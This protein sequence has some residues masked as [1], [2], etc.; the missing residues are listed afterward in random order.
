MSHL[1]WP[2]SWELKWSFQSAKHLKAFTHCV[3]HLSNSSSELSIYSTYIS[4]C[5]LFQS[6]WIL[7]MA[8]KLLIFPNAMSSALQAADYKCP[9]HQGKASLS[10]TEDFLSYYQSVSIP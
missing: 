10:I 6:V 7:F 3:I 8:F 5:P 1:Q 4:S 2:D 9:G